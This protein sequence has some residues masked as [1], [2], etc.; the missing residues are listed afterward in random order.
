MIIEV[1]NTIIAP[2]LDELRKYAGV[3]VLKYPT[4]QAQGYEIID[5]PNKMG[6]LKQ[7]ISQYASTL[8]RK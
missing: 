2:T 3:P 4:I 8:I 7:A 5:L 1:Q 6:V